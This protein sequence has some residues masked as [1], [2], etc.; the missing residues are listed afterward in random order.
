MYS[1]SPRALRNRRG[2]KV[3]K[4]LAERVGTDVLMLVGDEG[5]SPGSQPTEVMRAQGVAE[6][7]QLVL[8]LAIEAA[9]GT[10]DGG[11]RPAKRVWKA[12]TPDSGADASIFIAHGLAAILGRLASTPGHHLSAERQAEARALMREFYPL[13]AEDEHAIMDY[14]Q[15]VQPVEA[16]YH[17]ALWRLAFRAISILVGEEKATQLPGFAEGDFTDE[18]AA[19]ITWQICWNHALPAYLAVTDP[20]GL[21]VS[22]SHSPERPEYS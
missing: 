20:E 13:A 17:E 1:E 18:Y 10:P 16:R 3:L 4:R 22:H 5:W 12:M 9:G 11:D 21:N 2:Y 19:S 8:G 14:A 7:G 15:A 6:A